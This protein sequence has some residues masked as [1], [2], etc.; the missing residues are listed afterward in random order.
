MAVICEFDSEHRVYVA[1]GRGPLRPI[2]VE[3]HTRAEALKAFEV[4]VS[5]QVAEEYHFEQAMSHLADVDAGE[6]YGEDLG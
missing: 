3:G 2:V 1:A 4:A 5:C 6:P